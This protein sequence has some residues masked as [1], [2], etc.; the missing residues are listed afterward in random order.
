[1]KK[2]SVEEEDVDDD[3]NYV[4]NCGVAVAGWLSNTLRHEPEHG[5]LDYVAQMGA[6]CTAVTIIV[7]CNVKIRGRGAIDVD[8]LLAGFEEAIEKGLSDEVQDVIVINRKQ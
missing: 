7:A 2:L 6:I 3:W 4:N 5:E 1:M 8:N